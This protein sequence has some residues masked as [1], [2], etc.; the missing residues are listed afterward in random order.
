MYWI[1]PYACR[2][3]DFNFLKFFLYLIYN[4]HSISTQQY[5]D[6]VTCTHPFNFFII[7]QV[8]TQGTRCVALCCTAGP[9]HPL[10]R[11]VT[12]CISQPQTQPS[13]SISPPSLLA[14]ASW[15]SMSMICFCFVNRSLAPY[16]RLHI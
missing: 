9:H 13:A 15:P 4:V 6:P 1:H 5:S 3:I 10:V 7:D 14:N 2:P 12:V 16:F 8:L 11:N